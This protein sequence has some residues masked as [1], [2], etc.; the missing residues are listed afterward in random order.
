MSDSLYKNR[1]PFRIL[2]F[3]LQ[4]LTENKEHIE[5]NIEHLGNFVFRRSLKKVS[6]I[7]EISYDF[8]SFIKE[9]VVS[10]HPD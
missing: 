3:N 9:N 4:L 2:A 6:S 1:R 8:S 5:R 10:L 7:K